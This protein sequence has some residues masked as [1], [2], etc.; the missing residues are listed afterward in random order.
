MFYCH[1][2][3]I[4]I[5]FSAHYLYGMT[6]CVCLHVYFVHFSVSCFLM[7]FHILL[8]DQLIDCL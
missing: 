8:C 7:L 1:Y 5:K 3:L 2:L 6:Y 4:L